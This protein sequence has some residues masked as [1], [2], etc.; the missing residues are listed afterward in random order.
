MKIAVLGAGNIGTLL[1]SKLAQTNEVSLFTSNI[2]VQKEI[3]VYDKSDNIIFKSTLQNI[4]NEYDELKN[5]DL[6]FVT[7][8]SNVWHDKCNQIKNFIK[9]NAIIVFVPAMGGKEYMLESLRRTNTIIG[10]QRVPY[11]ARLKEKGKSV[12]MLDVKNKLYISG[13]NLKDIDIVEL[14]ENL[15]NIECIFIENYLN[16]TL[17]PSNPILHTTRLYSMFNERKYFDYEPFFYREWDIDSAKI[18]FSC[19]D[20]LQTLCKSLDK[21]DL[22]FV[23]SLKNYYESDTEEKFVNKMR[24]IESF[25]NIKAP[26]VK[27]ND[28]FFPDYNSRYFLE[29]FPFGLLIIKGFAVICDVDTPS[30]DKILNWVQKELDKEYL[31]GNKLIGK[32]LIETGIPQNYGIKTKEDIY[33]F[34]CNSKGCLKCKD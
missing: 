22:K 5:N 31:I 12:Y 6:I 23:K 8:P 33:S 13:I 32:N 21:I 7:Y 11:I 25:K 16:L 26:V 3:E 2:N 18:L 28:K 20:E 17:T 1:A 10:M 29:D 19:D 4:C 27:E 24:S 34:Y 14:I 15:L 9:D 30:I